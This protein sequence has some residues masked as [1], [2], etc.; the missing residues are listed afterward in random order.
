MAGIGKNRVFDS[1]ALEELK[2]RVTELMQAA[3]EV[4]EAIREEMNTLSE[5]AR[6]VPAEAKYD[7][8]DT[9]AQEL[10]GN[11][12]IEPYQTM[13]AKIKSK[14]DELN[15]EV[16]AY[17]A[18]TASVVNGLTA[19]AGDLI[20]MIEELKSMIGQGSL[21]L[22]LE[23]FSGK[24][25]EYRTAWEKGGKA[26]EAKMALAMTYLKGLVVFSEF[27][28]DPVNLSTGN[29]YYEKEDMTVRGRM[30]L[31]FKRYYNAMDKGGGI[32][33][34]G[35]S[36]SLEE[37]LT[38]AGD[39]AEKPP[40]L[41]LADGQEIAFSPA[42]A[43]EQ[44][45][46]YRDIHTGEEKLYGSKDGYRYQ[47]GGVTRLFDAQGRL[48]RKE[49]EN[50]NAILYTY[51][52]SGRL[53]KAEQSPFGGRFLFHYKEDGTLKTVTDH[54][55]RSTAFF[56]VEGRLTE[57]TDPE[58]SV[59]CY[60][61]EE[62]GRLRAV[63]NPRGIL[64]VRNEY[65][66]KGR[67]T[68][69]RFP[70]KGEMRY[71]YDER[72]N[73]TT[74]TE[75]NG[76]VITY[77]Q[78]ERLRNTEILYHDSR[79]SSTYDDGNRKTSHT[80]RNGNTTR[81][82]YDGEG[83]L[84]AVINALGIRTGFSYNADGKLLSVEH[85]GREVMK[86]SYDDN[87]RVTGSSDALGRTMANAYDERGLI[88]EV[89][90][91]DGSRT[92]FTYDERGNILTITDPYGVQTTYAYDDLNRV[93]QT[94]DG[95]GNVTRY[96]YD[97]KDRLI[98]VTN[99][100]GNSRKYT[101]NPSG[102]VERAQ[103]FDG[104][105]TTVTYNDLNRPECLTD[106]EGRQTL[107]RYDK[108]WN[109]SEEISPTGAVTKFAYDRDNRLC[110]VSLCM[111]EGEDPVSVVR[112]S[113]DP[114]GN[115]TGIRTGSA[116]LSEDAEKSAGADC[117]TTAYQYDALNRVTEA[118]NET[119]GV[120]RYEYDETGKVKSVTDPAGN[121]ISYTYNEAGE[122]IRET[123]GEG[124]T[125]SYEYNALGQPVRITDAL[126]QETIHTYEK[127]GRLQKTAYPDGSAV[128]YTYDR[129]G[130]VRTKENSDGYLLTYTYDCM[131]RVKKVASSNGQEKSYTYDVMGNVTSMTDANGNTT[132]YEYTA[133]G[134]LSAVTDALGNRTQYRYD[135]LDNLILIERMGEGEETARK[136]EYI[137]NPLGQ[138]E[139]VKDASGLEERYTY[140]VF[141]RMKEK[142]DRDG[143]TT[144][145]TYEADGK[146]KSILYADGKSVEMEYDALRRLLCVRDWLGITKIDR[147][148]KGQIEA[149]TD[150]AGKTVTYRYG[151][152]GERTGITYPDGKTVS[153]RYD[154]KLHLVQ[155]NLSDAD[156]GMT[157]ETDIT[158]HYDGKGRISEKH[159]PNGLRTF[160]HYGADGELTE[161]IH[162]D[163]DGVLDRYAYE[164]DP[165]GNKT[166]ITK[167]RRGL[168]EESG[169]Y[170]YGYDA[171]SRLAAVT[172]DG[173]ALRSYTYDPFGNRSLL[174]D[175]RAGRT[176]AYAYDALDRLTKRRETAGGKERIREYLYDNR[177]NLTEEREDG[178][179]LRGYAYNA[180]NRLE[181]AWDA[182]GREA[183]YEYNGLGQRT[184]RQ[185]GA[186][187]E[188]YLLDLTR[189]YHNL[190]GMVRGETVRNFYWDENVTAM[191]EMPDAE[192]AGTG[193]NI[194]HYYLQ[195]ELGSPVRVSGY[196][197]AYLTYGYDEFG[198]DLYRDLED[199]GIPN[200]Y[201][202]Q[203]EEQPFGYTGYRYD[204]ISGTYFAQA[205]E[206]QP[207][208]GRFTAEDV[209]R[210]NGAVPETLNRYGY[211]WG[212]PVGLVD[213]D[214]LYPAWLYGIYAHIQFQDE[215]LALYDQEAGALASERLY[216][217]VN[218]YIP[219]GGRT[220]GKG[221]ADVV[222]YNEEKVEIYEIKPISYHET[223]K[224]KEQLERYIQAYRSNHADIIVQEGSI[225]NVELLL[226]W[227]T[228]TFVYDSEMKI[229]YEM[230]ADSP[231]MIYYTLSYKEPKI[232]PSPIGYVELEEDKEKS[233]LYRA[234]TVLLAAM[235][236]CV[237]VEA[238]AS[239]V[240]DTLT[241]FFWIIP[242]GIERWLR[243]GGEGDCLVA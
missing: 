222:L 85:D 61:Y 115:L 68:R 185:T 157:G 38:F 237:A 128:S 230:F 102:K 23:E 215:F 65:D 81:Y 71:A 5:I 224:G 44:E 205:R 143:Y 220:G 196:D 199:A 208:N 151:K 8:L 119:G 112:Y 26:L 84:T 92:A 211:C 111:A 204:D 152:M 195:D 34:Q 121:T 83:N 134:K 37:R 91:P 29:F 77:V 189:P 135:A 228:D 51:E 140:D 1:A 41:H 209:I 233:V 141:G 28:R 181:R 18:A 235:E 74:L 138:V 116:A 35:W 57:V 184:A 104:A 175:H 124:R 89:T 47:K 58:G 231:G 63:K 19:A 216:G 73:T 22:S 43:P 88:R 50:G 45:K 159:F 155:M 103:D 75:R 76:N 178:G 59:T 156:A 66:E 48:I 56:F 226:W 170:E 214:G 219:G 16:P 9:A 165:M 122:L 100:E 146:T 217:D 20:A 69:Q 117:A 6:R 206:Y 229:K 150:H 110:E 192:K 101:Y 15:A 200:P 31:T 99:P 160:W 78:D 210:G 13:Q 109:V 118:V 24:L 80:D 180:R 93:I 218:V 197:G 55:G 87:G 161:L 67:I 174:E 82:Q 133:G 136:T 142:T 7:G 36:H 158:Y 107:R 53:S 207:Q 54:T 123:D 21:K 17:D 171:L 39:G 148:A 238:G 10:A 202:R 139:A 191:S 40:I 25:E 177:G 126:G 144:A 242:D 90:A 183:V 239:A 162:E 212:N 33:G 145:F 32:L 125:L 12:E 94:T 164:Y 236:F 232:Q 179:L 201:S 62:N 149:V 86:N 113:H 42:D 120:T 173:E 30:A 97:R 188:S 234:G 70:D 114:V 129:N 194:L 166:A 154:D 240:F 131:N 187:L 98:M 64:T 130:N 176:T 27:S 105:V 167:E 14:I 153:Y 52:E 221:F 147:D 168:K 106:K 169:R 225:E 137:R 193:E 79:E 3:Q 2:N 227:E 198:N 213:L 108:M 172:K 186:G 96:C 182:D 46:I 60:R 241:P 132:A 243:Y 11:L 4:T 190:L 163:R 203:G 223:G 72:K 49:D 127:G 95:N